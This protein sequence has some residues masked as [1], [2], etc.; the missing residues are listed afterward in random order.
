MSDK[1]RLF[2]TFN[3]LTSLAFLSFNLMNFPSYHISHFQQREA[4][5]CEIDKKLVISNNIISD[6]DNLNLDHALIISI[7]STLFLTS[8]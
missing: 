4:G 6:L 3:F 2:D 7:S 5:V 1:E 8:N